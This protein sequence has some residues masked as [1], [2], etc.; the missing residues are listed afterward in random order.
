MS[1]FENGNPLP[2]DWTFDSG[3]N[4]VGVEWFGRVVRLQSG[5][6]SPAL[7]DCALLMIMGLNITLKILNHTNTSCE[8]QEGN[9]DIP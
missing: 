7:R 8:K 1:V 6:D 4:R 2:T 9:K 3:Q 5:L